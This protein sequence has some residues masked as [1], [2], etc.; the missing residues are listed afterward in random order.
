MW[1][2]R[3]VPH[4]KSRAIR[5]LRLLAQCG[6]VAVNSNGTLTGCFLRPDEYEAFLRYKS[7]QRASQPWTCPGKK[8]S[9]LSAPAWT[10][11]TII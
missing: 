8:P 7:R 9:P 3:T 10:A 6:A 11:A 4:P 5:R 2:M 1:P